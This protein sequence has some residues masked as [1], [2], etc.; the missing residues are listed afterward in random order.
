MQKRIIFTTTLL[1][2]LLLGATIT[3]MAQANDTTHRRQRWSAED[4]ADKFSDKLDRELHFNRDQ[5]KQIHVINEDITRRMDAVKH[6]HTLPKK[7]KMQQ[8]KALNEERGQRFKTVLTPAQYKKWN[9]WEMKKKE[10]LEAKMD[11]KQ[12]KRQARQ[13]N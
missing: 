10:R 7:E 5:D 1:A 6:N 2:G 9:N 12:Q 4:R 11:K 8:M 13:Q 3:A